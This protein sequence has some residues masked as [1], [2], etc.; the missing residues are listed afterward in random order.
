MSNGYLT[1]AIL[2]QLA[3][4]LSAKV[5][6]DRGMPFAVVAR[7]NLFIKNEHEAVVPEWAWLLFGVAVCGVVVAR[8]IA[9]A[10]RPR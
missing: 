1:R 10:G 8:V 3:A 7:Q 9:A 6:A 5:P 2:E 4:G